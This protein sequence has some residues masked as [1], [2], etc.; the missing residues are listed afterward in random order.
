M[1]QPVR[2]TD[3]LETMTTNW[4]TTEQTCK[5]KLLPVA[6]DMV[7]L[8]INESDVNNSMHL[9]VTVLPFMLVPFSPSPHHLL[10][11]WLPCAHLPLP[12]S[13]AHCSCLLC[14][15]KALL[16]CMAVRLDHQK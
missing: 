16:R 6:G 9:T 14:L 7:A 10:S 1:L 13:C 2:K 4:N 5:F 15:P 8:S 11:T 12:D 3:Y